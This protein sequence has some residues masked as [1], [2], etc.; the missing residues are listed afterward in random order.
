MNF[1]P[2]RGRRHKASTE[3]IAAQVL[4]QRQL[5]TNVVEVVADDVDS[6]TE[7]EIPDIPIP[8]DLLADPMEYLPL[9]LDELESI[10]PDSTTVPPWYETKTL[11]DFYNCRGGGSTGSIQDGLDD[12]GYYDAAYSVHKGGDAGLA[13][14]RWLIAF[15]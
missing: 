4:D 3:L 9:N 14:W 15:E 2:P 7:F 13:H 5:L 10:L 1:G 6:G 11:G 8:K 12:D